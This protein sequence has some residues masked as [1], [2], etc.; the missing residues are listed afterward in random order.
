MFFHL[1]SAYFAL[2]SIFNLVYFD[3]HFIFIPSSRQS[4]I[5]NI[6]PFRKY[7]VFIDIPSKRVGQRGDGSLQRDVCEGRDQE[8]DVSG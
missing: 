3:M 4:T 6:F 2:I 7:P 1:F 8:A 5:F